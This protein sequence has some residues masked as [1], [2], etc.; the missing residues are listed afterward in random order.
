MPYTCRRCSDVQDIDTQTGF[1]IRKT[2]TS[3]TPS[4]M[5]MTP[6]I[7]PVIGPLA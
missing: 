7:P 6:R 3:P 5:K 2:P 4:A 1:R